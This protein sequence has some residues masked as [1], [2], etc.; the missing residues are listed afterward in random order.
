MAIGNTPLLKKGSEEP[1]SL[2][3]KFV[4]LCAEARQTDA[5][6]I[7]PFGYDVE[8]IELWFLVISHSRNF[9]EVIR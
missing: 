1:L 6:T 2:V 9:L 3:N 7:A 8:L 5:I 4:V